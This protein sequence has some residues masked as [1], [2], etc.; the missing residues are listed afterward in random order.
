M[1][2]NPCD[3]PFLDEIFQ[4]LVR[5][6][7][8]CA[9][10]GN[11]YHALYENFDLYQQLFDRLGFR[12]EAHPRDFYYFRGERNLSDGSSRMA[13]FV[14]ILMEFLE[15]RAEPVAE[16]ILTGEFAL[17]ELPHFATERYRLYMKESGIVDRDGLEGVVNALERYGFALRKGGAFRFRTPVYRFFDICHAVLQADRKPDESEVGS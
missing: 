11:H 3:L 1:I 14:F 10:D 9:E 12:L 6:R 4:R 7:H 15:G 5:G 8:I 13:L 16:S 2:D 17:D